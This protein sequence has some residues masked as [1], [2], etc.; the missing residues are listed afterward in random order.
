[1]AYVKMTMSPGHGRSEIDEILRCPW[2]D[3]KY[4]QSARNEYYELLRIESR[5][6]EEDQNMVILNIVTTFCSLF[7]FFK[8]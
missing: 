5:L 8:N 7:T 2:F 1:M 3:Q 4:I 6:T